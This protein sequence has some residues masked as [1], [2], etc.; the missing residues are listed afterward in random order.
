MSQQEMRKKNFFLNFP[1][2]KLESN[3]RSPAQYSSWTIFYSNT[4][5]NLIVTHTTTLIL[6]EIDIEEYQYQFW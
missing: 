4:T 2:W 5:K 3:P 6:R 1:T